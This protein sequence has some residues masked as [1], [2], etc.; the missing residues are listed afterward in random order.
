MFDK[1]HFVVSDVYNPRGAM[2]RFLYM[3]GLLDQKCAANLRLLATK[4]NINRASDY[5]Y[6]NLAVT[7]STE[8]VNGID[9]IHPVVKPNIDYSTAVISKGL[10]QNGEI[11]FEFVPDN[12]DDRDAAKQAT[13]MVH[14]IVNQSSDPHKILQHWIMDA[15][16]HK[17]GEMLISP[18][19][20]QITRYIKTKG[21]A[22]QLQAF[23]A[24]AADA[25]LTAL[26]T[27]KRKSSVNIDQ[28]MKETQ[29]WNQGAIAERRQNILN[30]FQE[31]MKR[32]AEGEDTMD[33]SLMPPE[34][35]TPVVD[36][37][38]AVNEAVARNTIYDAEYKLTGYNLNIKFRPIAQHYWM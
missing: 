20:E 26:R 8:P 19:R 6:L 29:Q 18:Y 28:V 1:S 17:N 30:T 2:E 35:N 27:S 16:L 38:A 24:Q 32:G 9:Y 23:E 7:Q 14:K 12:E 34:D 5:H 4:N 11:N 15:L 10:M 25:G 22:D 36:G 13:E 31:A 37:E 33:E 3:K 21:T